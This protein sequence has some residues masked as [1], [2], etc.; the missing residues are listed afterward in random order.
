[1]RDGAVHAAPLAAD[2]L[3][4][5]CPS[6]GASHPTI[7]DV[8]LVLRDTDAWLA[9]EAPVVMARR[10][11]PPALLQ[12]VAAAAGGPLAR[13][14]ALARTY[15]AGEPCALRDVISRLASELPRPVLD[16]GCGR[17]VLALE[18][19]V[20]L[21]LNFS[22]LRHYPG[23]RVLGDAA[24]PPFL[25]GAF[26]TVMLLNVLD[27]CRD[28]ALVL[29]QAEALLA[30]GGTLLTSCAFAWNEGITPAAARFDADRLLRALDGHEGALP[31]RLNLSVQAVY[32]PVPWRLRLTDRTVHEHACQV[33]VARKAD[34]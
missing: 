19:A 33:V 16:V 26:G 13:D 4:L 18:G 30:P 22:L 3:G 25:A 27:S 14:L 11:L 8:H 23:L 21:D 12:R 7:D 5:R 28:P 24:D 1:M 15:G 2:E 6:C 29:A 17:G 9:S 10:D 31:Y 20:G 34:A 32:D